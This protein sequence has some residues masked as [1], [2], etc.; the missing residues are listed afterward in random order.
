MYQE[1]IKENLETPRLR[2]R[3]FKHSDSNAIYKYG[4]DLRVLKYLDWIG[5]VTREEALL[6]I[7]GYYLSRPGIYAISLKENDLCIGSID[8]RIDE[9]NDK[10][11]FGY[12]LDYDY[13]NLGYMS[14]VL[15]KI[16]EHCFEDLELNRVESMHYRLNPASG[17]VMTKCGM[18][19]E[20]MGIQ[21]YKIKG[22]YQDALHY[23]IT[24]SMWQ[25]H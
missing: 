14:E 8:I 21:E 9:A 2:L 18:K 5:V 4:S 17:R 11:S 23:G 12:L 6:N 19:F 3:R 13:W 25:N 15:L 7:D 20:G 24:R 16:L 1:R 10:A 22:I